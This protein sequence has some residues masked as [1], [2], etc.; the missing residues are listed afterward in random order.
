M[1]AVVTVFHFQEILMIQPIFS[2][3]FMC[4]IKAQKEKKKC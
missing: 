2:S 4:V 3:D 1:T